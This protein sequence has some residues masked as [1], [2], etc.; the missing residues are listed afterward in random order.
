MRKLLLM[1][2]AAS[3][4]TACSEET[5]A[6]TDTESLLLLDDAAVLAYGAMDMAHPGSHFI[7]RLHRLPEHLKLTAEQQTQIRALLQAF[8]EA[9]KADRE[10]LAAIMRRAREAHQAGKS[11]E[12]VRAILAEGDPIRRRLHEAEQNLH[13]QIEA[14]LTPAQKE[15]LAQTGPNRCQAFALTDAQKTEI[16]ALVAAFNQTHAADIATVRQAFEEARAAYQNGASREEIRAILQ[17]AAAA[18]ERLM[19]AHVQLHTAI[20]AVLTSEQRQSGCYGPRF[21]IRRVG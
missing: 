9:T 17:K 21:I 2:L 11:H 10:A 7:A 15:W 4:I 5:V 8:A 18:M 1:L 16:T 12:E 19:V 6:P 14:L 20:Q 13:T 3:S